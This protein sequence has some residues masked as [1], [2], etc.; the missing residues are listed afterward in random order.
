MPGASPDA[1]YPAAGAPLAGGAA[2][3]LA[4]TNYCVHC[5]MHLYDECRA[6][7]TRKNAFYP[8]CPTCGVPAEPDATDPQLQSTG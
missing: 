1:G 6:C 2:G 8:F 7:G 4:P 3:V 5:G